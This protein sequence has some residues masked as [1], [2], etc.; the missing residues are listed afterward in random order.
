MAIDRLYTTEISNCSTSVEA[1]AYIIRVDPRS[2]DIHTFNFDEE[3]NRTIKSW[4]KHMTRVEKM[5]EYAPY[6]ELWDKNT[7]DIERLADEARTESMRVLA[8]HDEPQKKLPD[9][10]VKGIHVRLRLLKGWIGSH[11]EVI[12]GEEGYKIWEEKKGTLLQSQGIPHLE[13]KGWY[14]QTLTTHQ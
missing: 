12:R 9:E 8:E 13:M 4:Q 10:V 7:R 3:K 1:I 14:Y 5:A 2:E 11:V 6:F